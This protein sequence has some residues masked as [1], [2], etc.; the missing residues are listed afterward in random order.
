MQRFLWKG[1]DGDGGDHLIEW[2]MVIRPKNKVGLSIGRLKEKNKSLLLKWLWRFPLE[3]E[4]I[5][6]KVIRSKFGLHTN[7][8][9]AGIASRYTFLS[10]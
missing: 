5:W 3:Q 9:D 2:K 8:W 4:S 10:P 6:A 7:R 1:V